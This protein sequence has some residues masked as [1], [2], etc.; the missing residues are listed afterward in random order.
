MEI[1]TLKSRPDIRENDKAFPAYQQFVV[2]LEEIRKKE[3]PDV[4]AGKIN[5]YVGEI[6]EISLSGREMKKRLNTVQSNI[7]R[8]LV[9]ELKIA[10]KNYY[11]MLW[12]GIGMASFGVPIGVALGASLDNMAFIGIGIPIGFSIGI[13]LGAGMDKKAKEEGRQLDVE[14]KYL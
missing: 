1:I 13:A 10:P 6:N 5:E 11:R 8:L 7:V 4:V 14:V 2:L 12:M 3:V 9:K